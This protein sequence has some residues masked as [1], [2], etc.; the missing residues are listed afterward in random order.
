MTR[1]R[2][3]A[4]A[5]G[6]AVVA[7]ALTA[8]CAAGK[9]AQTAQE[10]PTIDGTQGSVGQIQLESVAL[11]APSGSSYAKGATVPL[12][13]YIV[14][15]GTTADS[16]TNIQSAS[17][18]GGY[19]VTSSGTSSASAGSSQAPSSAAAS[20]GGSTGG[21][22]PQQIGAGSAVGFGL[23]DLGTGSGSSPNSIELKGLTTALHPGMAVKITFTFA[24]A[25][26]TTLTVPVQLSSTPN[27]KSL[28]AEASSGSE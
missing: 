6:A 8:G 5:V 11:H 10:K 25:G 4:T 17:F 20:S 16:L 21:T 2:A 22:G 27:D 13:V 24:K 1:F 19:S 28:P 7:V 14:N 12:T 26:Q 18:P 15:N 23:Q 9:Q 3:A